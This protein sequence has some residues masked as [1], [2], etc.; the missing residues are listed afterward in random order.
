MIQINQS[1]K[2]TIQAKQS[3]QS[4]LATWKGVKAEGELYP[5]FKH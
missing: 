4:S 1:N 5:P 2:T 3:N